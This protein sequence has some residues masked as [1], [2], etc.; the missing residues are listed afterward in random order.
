MAASAELASD[1]A[2]RIVAAMRSSVAR[3]G[4]SGSTFEHV[5]REAG[6]SR[7]LLHYHFG[8]KEALVAEVVRQDCAGRMER[9]ESQLVEA[10]SADDVVEMLRRSLEEFVADEFVTVLHEFF[11]LSRRNADVAEEFAAL[12]TNTRELVAGMLT[13]KQAEGVLRLHGEP[14]AIATLIFALGDGIA[15]RMLAQ[16][17]LD[18]GPT[19][20][21]AS[22][23]V[24]ALVS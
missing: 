3:R 12:L 4:V 24:R 6:V 1:R 18:W 22:R 5:A 8:T 23:A 21:A 9:L 16:P 17:E 2:Q 14:T 15:M 13:A 19:I 10:T 11:T 7:G 20:E